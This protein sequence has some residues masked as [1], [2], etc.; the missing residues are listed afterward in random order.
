MRPIWP[1]TGRAEELAFIAGALAPGDGPSGVVL[2]GAAGVGKTR[3][4]REALA[5]AGYRGMTTRWVAATEAARRVPLG[6][7]ST[8][9]GAVAD[10]PARVIGQATDDLLAGDRG[11]GVIVGVDDAH[12]LDPASALLV[13]Q[14]VLRKRASVVFTVRTGEPAP[15]AVTAVWKD[16]GLDRL[17]VQPLSEAETGALLEAVLA[18]PVDAATVGR[19]WVLT[20]GNALF[21]RHLVDSEAQS[22]RLRAEL[23]WWTWSGDPMISPELAELVEARMGRLSRSVQDVVDLLALGEPLAVEVIA[24]L[25]DPGAVEE[26]E[27]CGLITMEWERERPQVRLIHPL[28]GEV[29]RGRLGPI[30]AR[31][32]SGRIALALA[33]GSEDRAVDT[34]R[35]AVL[36]LDSDLDPDPHLLIA[37]ARSASSLVDLPLTERLARA[38]VDAD[39]GFEPQIILGTALGFQSRGAEAEVVLTRL[40]GEVSTDQQRSVV[41]LCRVANLLWVLRNPVGAAAALDRAEEIVDDSQCRLVL[42]A[43]RSA[44]DAARG[45]ARQAARAAVETLAAPELPPQAVMIA[46]YGLVAAL[47]VLGRADEIGPAAARGYA[48]ASR[49]IEVAFLRFGLAFMHVSGLRLAGYLPEA[50]QFALTCRQASS[51]MPGSA[52]L[53][54]MALTAQASLAQ[55]DIGASL[56]SLHEVR[57][58]LGSVDTQGF[59]FVCLLS[60]TEALSVAGDPVAARRAC[61]QLD[62]ER[63]P[64]FAYLEPEVLLARAWV[65]AAEGSVRQAIAIASDAAAAARHLDQPAHEVVALH[66][67]V[68][69]GDRTVADRLARLAVI[70]DGPRGAAAAAHAAA[71]RDHDGAA[72]TRASVQLEEM[73]DLLAAADAAAH[74]AAAH[75]EHGRSASAAVAAARSLRLVQD[76]GGARSPATD[77]SARPLPLTE[78]ERE[79]VTLAARGL[80]NRAIAERLVISVRTVEGHVYNATAKLGAT[81][82]SDFAAFLAGR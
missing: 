76:C 42:T 46:T 53:Y 54:G 28:H 57:A 51:D 64:A 73:G 52:R 32:L 10:D 29:R 37:A 60:L 66:T 44:I 30:R 72:L 20:G 1:L 6:A 34:L 26:A 24:G 27:A 21:L 39:G 63:H 45:R 12:L 67:A 9:L 70:V 5:L 69:F 56:R 22:G 16:E 75:H 81:R 17:E 2:A 18:G 78:R 40:A 43:T 61:D 80:S 79:I 14:L 77:A 55:G 3:L 31:R 59:G 50:H 25:A 13:H 33:G 35:R 8:L 71:L 11:A 68:R 23:G 65:T 74:A 49:S 15:D 58:G 41:A 19:M 47:G 38:A 48:E 4:A 7:F 62:A 36:A 82:R